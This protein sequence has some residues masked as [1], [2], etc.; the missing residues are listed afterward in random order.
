M[1]LIAKDKVFSLHALPDG[2]LYSYLIEEMEGQI[3]VGY[4]MVSFSGGK[5]SNVTKNMYMLTKFGSSYKYS[6]SKIKTFF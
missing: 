1:K 5:I 6:D 2:F 4:K 3:K